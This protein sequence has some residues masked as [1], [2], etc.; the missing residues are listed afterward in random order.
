MRWVVILLVLT[1]AAASAQGPDF[2]A[3]ILAVHNR[4]RAA[5]DLPPLVWNESLVL[6]AREWAER[7]AA[8]GRLEHSGGDA[9]GENLW[10]GTAGAYTLEQMA[11]DWA[12][13]KRDFMP[14][15]FPDVSRSRN[16]HEV[17]H[18]TQ[19]IWR[20]TTSVGCALATTKAW[21]V[22]VCRYDPSGN[23]VGEAPY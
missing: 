18:Y 6:G 7:L 9:Y 23:W 3:R 8:L 11:G 16:W 22:L 17:G 2:A 4:E 21:D 19:M 5:L 15:T 1:V 20:H 10:M 13:E 12:D 14:G